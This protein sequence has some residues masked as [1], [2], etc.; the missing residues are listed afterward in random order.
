MKLNQPLLDTLRALLAR[1]AYLDN[2]DSLLVNGTADALP[3]LHEYFEEAQRCGMH[4]VVNIDGESVALEEI[5]DAMQWSV[6]IGKNGLIDKLGIPSDLQDQSI[7]FFDQA[8][9]KTWANRQVG[10]KERYGWPN[11]I[12]L[13]IDG[14]EGSVSGPR[15]RASALGA[16]FASFD[17][18][19]NNQFPSKDSITS[20]VYLSSELTSHCILQTALT[21]GDIGSDDFAPLRRWAEQDAA[22]LLCNET[23]LR[24]GTPI[25]ILRGGRRVS[26]PIGGQDLAP[27]K[28][29]LLILQGAVSWA[30]SEHRDARHALLIDRLTLE[31]RDDDSLIGLLRRALPAA[32]QDAR[33][34]YQLFVIEQKDAAAKETREILKDVRTQADLFASKVRDL[35]STFLR[36]LLASLLLIGL[37]LIGRLNGDGIGTLIESVPVDGFF[38]ILS[39]YFAV[40][41]SLQIATHWRDLHLTT[42]ELEK[43]WDATR[44]H[45]PGDKVNKLLIDGIRPR[46]VTFVFAVVLIGLLN[47]AVAL[48]LWKW[49]FVFQALLG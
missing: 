4:P 40:S 35:V 45:L 26:L 37:G 16:D 5:S 38:R 13:L 49:K 11:K 27:T 24:E 2:R 3:A 20:L 39:L 33:E 48:A 7:L 22:V 32:L 18:A 42:G 34:R 36:D 43:W 47:G 6:P 23:A 1:T 46:K 14:I 8:A 28:E 15:I 41:A 30:F 44:A 29:Q 31:V 17:E 25:A 12:T 9:F 10:L 21:T 19:A